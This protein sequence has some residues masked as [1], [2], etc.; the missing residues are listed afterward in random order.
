MLRFIKHNLTEIIGIEMYPV[1]SLIIF[2]GFFTFMLYRV[3]RM[4]K[5][6][7]DHLGAIPLEES[8]NNTKF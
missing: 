7:I 1:I 8:D 3:W 2:V 5:E 4:K 6:D